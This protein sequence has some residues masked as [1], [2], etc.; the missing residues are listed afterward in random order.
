MRAVVVVAV[1]LLSACASDKLALAPA[2]GVD[3][4]GHWQLNDAD[5]DDPLRLMQSQNAINSPA[6]QSGG[7][8]GGGQGGQGG[9]GRGGRQGGRG[10]PGVG[11]PGGPMGPSM[12]GMG[13]MGAGLRWPGKSLEVTQVAG[14][15]TFNSDGKRQVFRPIAGDR[16]PKPHGPLPE[17]PSH[18]RDA[19]VRSR[20]DVPPPR[21][22]WEERTLIIQGDDRTMIIRRSK[23][24]IACRTMANA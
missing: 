24:A 3:L 16:K 17:D 21:C 12:P 15:V 18:G 6:E 8:G 10:G 20:A 4:T 13:A 19:P 1:M 9:G 7:Q 11:L 23:S 2:P 14:I 5:S 22:G